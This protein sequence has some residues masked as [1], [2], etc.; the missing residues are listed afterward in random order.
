MLDALL[1]GAAAQ[2]A[3]VLAGLVVYEVRV[4]DRVVG[5]IAGYG[6]GALIGAITFDLVPE[7]HV[8]Q[9]LEAALW[10]L[11]GAAVYIVADRLVDRFLAPAGEGGDKSQDPLGIV[12]GAVVDGVPESL[13]FGIGL[14]ALL[15]V[16][17]PFLVAVWVSNIPQ[18]L[19]PSAELAK[20][21]WR[22]LRVTIMWSAVVIA[23]GVTAAAGFAGA[24]VL[25][26]GTSGRAAAFA[27]GGL[28][29]MLTDSLVPFAYQRAGVQA[30]IW[31]VIGFAVAL[32]MA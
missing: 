10:L 28:L 4:P 3:L 16:S 12:V 17:L 6:V 20:S 22:P 26:P 24:S 31:T 13:I 2:S 5:A 15:P 29:A 27:A 32:A 14:A 7:A 25:G 30:G 18:A 19:A 11:A 23:C 8:V 1:L 21:G 9:T